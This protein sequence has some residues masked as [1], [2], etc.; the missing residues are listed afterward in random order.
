MTPQFLPQGLRVDA[1]ADADGDACVE[2]LQTIVVKPPWIDCV[3]NGGRS[4][5]FQRN[6]I[7]CHKALKSQDC[8]ALDW[9]QIRICPLRM[10]NTPTIIARSI[11]AFRQPV[12]SCLVRYWLHLKKRA[13]GFAYKHARSHTAHD[14]SANPVVVEVLSLFHFSPFIIA[15]P[16]SL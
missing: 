15:I 7:P 4:Y 8:L 10:R 12:S 1:G 16:Q 2:T 6:S 9:I 5:V 3:A 13:L 14:R 11:V